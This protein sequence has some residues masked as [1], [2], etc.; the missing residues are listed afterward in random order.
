MT[1]GLVGYQ[2]SGKSSLYGWLTDTE[3]DPAQAHRGQSAMAQIPDP[4]LHALSE[5]YKSKKV[6]FAALELIDTPGLSRA[7]EQA[8]ARLAAM[9]QV[10]SMVLVVAAYAGSDPRADVTSF[11]DDLLL[12]D[13]EIVTGRIERLRESVKK[14]RPNRDAELAELAVLEPL[15][16]AMES[17]KA[18]RN[19][20]MTDEQQR[21]TRAFGLLT[22]KPKLVLFNVADD[23][24]QPDRFV[25]QF[26][27]HHTVTARLGLEGELAR[28]EQS[29]RQEFE[30]ELG[31]KG[32]RRC[33][34]LEAIL[35]AS[36]HI[37]FYTAAPNEV[38][39]WLL[40]RGAT[41]VEAAAAV[42]TD[43]ARG[44]I[45]AETMTC[46]DL[47]RLGSEREVKAKHLVRSE[48]KDYVVADGDILLIRFSV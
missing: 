31:L 25:H 41:A 15:L 9:R 39:A 19:I 12:A 4:R 2:G 24:Q 43:L 30:R 23:E 34:M 35:D 38:R 20:G 3:P 36:G 26:E 21:A 17:G 33:A 48:P 28:M 5:I 47:V 29:D 27:D 13:M 42:H 11:E 18:L 10:G 32:D 44:F 8:A 40:P 46:D 6:T 1:I 7:H 37:R 16:E 45:R 22:E 14:P